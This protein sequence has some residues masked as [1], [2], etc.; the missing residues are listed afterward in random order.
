MLID[1]LDPDPASAVLPWLL[2]R[3]PIGH[4]QTINRRLV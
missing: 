1:A 2:F 4:R 3:E